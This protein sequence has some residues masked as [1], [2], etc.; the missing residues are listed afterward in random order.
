MGGHFNGHM[1]PAPSGGNLMGL[2][3]YGAGAQRFNVSRADLS[4]SFDTPGQ[5]GWAEAGRRANNLCQLKGFRTGFLNGHFFP[6]GTMG[7]ICH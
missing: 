7:L 3:C 1:A 2:I 5:A 6:D 4:A